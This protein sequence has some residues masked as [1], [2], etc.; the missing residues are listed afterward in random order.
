VLLTVEVPLL[1]VA[2]LGIS[3]TAKIDEFVKSP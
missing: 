3:S 1:A 2:P